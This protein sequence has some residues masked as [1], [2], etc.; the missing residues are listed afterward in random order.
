MCPEGA[1]LVKI[2]FIEN[3]II[4]ESL[5]D[6]IYAEFHEQSIKLHFKTKMTISSQFFFKSL[7]TYI[8]WKNKFLIHFFKAL[9]KI[10]N[11]P[12]ICFKKI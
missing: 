3:R 5:V 6:P 9:D 8:F 10:Q 7:N 12:E 2:K 4:N 1:L 11:N